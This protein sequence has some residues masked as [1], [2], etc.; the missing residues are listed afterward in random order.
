MRQT[1]DEILSQLHK[2]ANQVNL[3][4]KLYELGVSL[5]MPPGTVSASMTNTVDPYSHT[6][7]AAFEA[8]R[9]NIFTNVILFHDC[10]TSNKFDN[11]TLNAAFP[12]NKLNETV[13]KIERIQQLIINNRNNEEFLEVHDDYLKTRNIFPSAILSPQCYDIYRA[14]NHLLRIHIDPSDESHPIC[15]F[16]QH[17][18]SNHMIMQNCFSS[19]QRYVEH[20]QSQS[21]D[22]PE[23]AVLLE[24]IL[25]TARRAEQY[26]R[27]HPLTQPTTIYHKPFDDQGQSLKNKI[28]AFKTHLT[29]RARLEPPT[30]EPA[31]G[32]IR[33]CS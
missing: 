7:L 30:H 32:S 27:E 4:E 20:H 21:M 28:E 23:G 19:V 31:L 13:I 12:I 3:Y 6:M 8:I 11:R 9:I 24:D 18:H 17:V 14:T 22:D 2:F 5:M 26:Y 10:Y 1:L 33:H 16:D 25:A 29:Q 15:Q